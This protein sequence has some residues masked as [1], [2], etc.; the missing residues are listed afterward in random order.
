MKPFFMTNN[1][2]MQLKLNYLQ[3]SNFQL[4]TS[5]DY[6]QGQSKDKCCVQASAVLQ[7]SPNFNLLPTDYTRLAEL[8]FTKLF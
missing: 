2:D 4:M 1:R 8:M 6:F 5:R 3:N 7:Q